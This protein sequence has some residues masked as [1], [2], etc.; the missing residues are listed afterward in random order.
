MQHFGILPLIYATW[1]ACVATGDDSL[2][3][4]QRNQVVSVD[5]A[6]FAVLNTFRNSSSVLFNP[7]SSSPPFFQVFDPEFHNILGPNPTI[8]EIAAN[9]S[10]AFAHEAPIYYPETNE[11]FFASNAGGALEDSGIN[12]NNVVSKIDMVAVESALASGQS[13][14]RV[15]VQRLSLSEDVQMTNGGTG[16]YNGALVLITSGRGTRPPSIVT[17]N[18]RPP[19]NTTVLLNNFYGR[20][21]NSLNDAKIHP[22]GKIFFT[23]APYGSQNGF[24]PTAVLPNQVY[25]FDPVTKAVRLVAGDF[26]ICNGIALTPDG[27]TAYVSDTG[28]SG[29][30]TRPSTIYAFDV[31]PTT[32]S[33]TNRRIFAYAD[34]GIPDGIQVDAQGNV[35][36]GDSKAVAI[37]I[38]VSDSY[39]SPSTD[40][41]L[42]ARDTISYHSGPLFFS[43]LTHNPR[44]NALQVWNS[45]GTLLGKF[46][47]GSTSA[48]MAFAGDGRLSFSRKRKFS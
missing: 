2:L 37:A 40:G 6:T 4:R 12:K 31:D 26:T 34:T 10:F 39:S 15:P 14:A 24:R 30:S 28:A 29:G 21:F 43:R 41:A 22:S 36:S 18:P 47:V 7:T 35:Y 33:F 9:A 20:Q 17:V 8:T 5:P 16:P 27:K 48:N 1:I 13:P 3:R 46:F 38:S 45:V 23:D 42:R 19:Y 32:H 44:T 11:I 25:R